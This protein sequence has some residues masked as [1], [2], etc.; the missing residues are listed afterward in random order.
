MK[1]ASRESVA[2]NNSV[3]RRH[4][5]E[6]T[7]A[8]LEPFDKYYTLN[9]SYLQDSPY[10]ELPKFRPFEGVEFLRD[11]S[12]HKKVFPLLQYTSRDKAVALYDS[13]LNT[14]MFRGWLAAQR[15]RAACEAHE[16]VLTAMQGFDIHRAAQE[17]DQTQARSLYV[18]IEQQLKALQ[19]SGANVEVVLKLKKQLSVLLGKMQGTPEDH[20]SSVF[21]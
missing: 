9:L 16:A 19:R 21:S 1:I 8:F 2:I 13:F 15:Q 17:M 5:R 4:F 11:L 6:L 12:S 14:A 20:P 7:I 10:L 3:L 18:R